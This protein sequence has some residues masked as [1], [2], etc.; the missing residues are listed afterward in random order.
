MYLVKV[1]FFSKIS[2]SKRPSN[3]CPI[4]V[5]DGVVLNLFSINGCNSVSIN[6]MN[7]S[8][9]P[10]VG[11]LFLSAWIVVGNVKSLRLSTVAIPITIDFGKMFTH[12][13]LLYCTSPTIW[14]KSS[15]D[16]PSSK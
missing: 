15:S 8:E 13:K 3:D 2:V 10:V 16:E 5:F 6:E 7:W 9:C 4:I 1:G 11:Y 14:T 12:S